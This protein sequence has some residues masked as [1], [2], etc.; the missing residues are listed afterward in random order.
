MEKGWLALF[1]A[2]MALRSSP[3]PVLDARRGWAK[4]GAVLGGAMVVLVPVTLLVFRERLGQLIAALER[5]Q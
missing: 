4:L 3:G 2:W 5:L 1:F